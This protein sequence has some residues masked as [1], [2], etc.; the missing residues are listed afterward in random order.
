MA[1]VVQQPASATTP[2]LRVSGLSVR[3]GSTQVLDE[4]D[5]TIAPGELVAVTGEPGAG[6]TTLMRC[7]AGDLAPASGSISFAGRGRRE[8]GVVWQDLELCENLDVAGNLMLGQERRLMFSPSRFHA[9]AVALL[10][11]FEIPIRDTMRPVAGLPAGERQ[12]IAVAR[13]LSSDPRLLILDDP[14]SSL[15][16]AE[17][18]QVEGLITSLRRHGTAVLL[19]T[20]DIQQL[21]R[22]ADRIVVLRRGRVVAE[23][24]PSSTHPDD[25]RALIS[26]QQVDTSARRQLTR[27]GG[28]A[29]RLVSADPSSSLALILSALRSALEIDR[30][31]IHVV[32]DDTLVC[33]ASLGFA[34]GQLEALD[35]LPV[36][37]A[38]GPAG[39]AATGQARV[40]DAD[41]RSPDHG[42]SGLAD[43]IAVSELA[44]SWSVPVLGPE[45]VSGVIT[46]F[47]LEPGQPQRD[48]LDLLTLYAVY[49]ASALER[50]RLLDQVTSRNRVL[51]TVRE[52]LQT[53]AGP[54]TA[55]GEGLAIAL[56]T[57][58]R[59][60]RADEIAL[61]SRAGVGEVAWRGYSGPRGT[62]LTSVSDAL[63]LAGELALTEKPRDGRA[64]E[65]R[66]HEPRRVLA[67]PFNAPAGPTALV[68]MWDEP[69]VRDED[70]ALIEDAAH[71]LNLALERE[72]A[73][74]AHQEAAA[75]RRSR[76]LQRGFLSRLSHE[77]RTPL[78][79]IRGY[80]SSLM[81]PDVT[82]D[83]PSQARFLQTIATESSRL[84][85]LVDDLLDYSAIESGVMRLQRDWCELPLVVA[86]AVSCLPPDWSDS[87]IVNCDPE[88]PAIWADHDRLEQVVVNLLN[89]AVRH[90]PPG[91][92]VTVRAVPADVAHVQL[93]V[94]DDGEG[95]PPELRG[96]PFDSTRR[97]R[98]RS[99]GAGLGLSIARGI[100]MAHGG[101][102]ELADAPRGTTFRIVLPVEE[103]NQVG[104]GIR[105]D[106][107]GEVGSEAQ[108]S[109]APGV[110]ART[111]GG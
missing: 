15:G 60:L 101:T 102:I 91:T 25:V 45:G 24:D 33:E 19:I 22:M 46:A 84:G 52:M 35:R 28:L 79:A 39:L 57:L 105:D 111:A 7:L 53:L 16:A 59:G 96:A 65:L 31:C 95:F 32:S 41:L 70:T 68:A 103:L 8:I 58:R 82:W 67:V 3:L 48:E 56:E 100:L 20:R 42:W 99:A 2:L 76:E 6:K 108:L 27:L 72:E 77:L 74:L 98:S 26:G 69:R 10:E 78:T 86:A 37:E 66:A 71:S 75:L 17:A 104:G 85:R 61:M 13:A 51:E 80:A 50:D 1:T 34:P 92:R 110:R 88:L 38:G 63:R 62:A 97:H 87:V 54:V 47:R 106:A 55:G 36:G 21:F 64:R 81:A 14:T 23:L 11:R 43:A 89:N 30:V 40:V 90:N 93:E 9:R 29:D 49:A 12:M 44:S 107:H 109:S 4:V 73:G 5:L 83:G 94:S 18:R